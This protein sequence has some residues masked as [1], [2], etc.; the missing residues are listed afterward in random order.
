MAKLKGCRWRARQLRNA[1]HKKRRTGPR[2]SRAVIGTF[3]TLAIEF[4]PGTGSL[5]GR[6]CQVYIS[7]GDSAKCQRK[8]RPGDGLSGGVQDNIGDSATCQ[9]KARPGDGL[10]GGVQDNVPGHNL[11]TFSSQSGQVA[12]VVLHKLL[13]LQYLNRRR[14]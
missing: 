14:K 2:G 6:K 9:R 11:A 13:R 5:R 4:A 3:C 12:T 7:I 1:R 10:S 8:A